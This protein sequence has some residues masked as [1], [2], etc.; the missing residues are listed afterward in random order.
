MVPEYEESIKRLNGLQS[1]AKV[2]QF[3]ARK[4][5]VELEKKLLETQWY[6]EKCNIQLE[7]IDQRNVIHVTGTKG[8]GST[9]AFTES[10]LRQLGFKTGFYRFI[11]PTYSSPHLIHHRERIRINGDPISESQFVFHFK[12]IYNCLEKAVMESKG[13]KSMP[14]FFQFL[15]ILAF[16]VFIE[17]KVD[18]AIIEVGIGGRYDCTNVIRNPVVSGVT[19][20][21][22]DHMS[23]LGNTLK[24]IA[25]Q[26]G[27]IFKSG[28]VAIVSKQSDDAMVIFRNLA[29]Y[30]N[31]VLRV[32][33]EFSAYGWPDNGVQCGI[34]GAHQQ[35]N[36]SLALQLAKISADFFKHHDDVAT[37]ES[38]ILPGFVVPQQFLDGIRLCNWPGRC[39]IVKRESITYYLD[40][41]HTPKS[42]QC[43]IDWFTEE[44]G[45]LSSSEQSYPYR[46]LLFNCSKGRSYRSFL[47]K[48]DNCGFNL[49]LFCP[50]LLH[51][52]NNQLSHGAEYK[53]PLHRVHA[54]YWRCFA[55]AAGE[56]YESVS[57]ALHRIEDLKDSVHKDIVVLV[58][59]SLHL[60]GCVLA[61]LKV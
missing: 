32:A 25:W 55:V 58:T 1:N 12:H 41:A 42:L 18:V 5:G 24:L 21:D 57:E 19:V 29:D 45:K 16:H 61:F 46:V 60:V 3:G 44:M 27:G 9:C 11:F 56:D 20:L 34:S 23:L 28:S 15:T 40:G 2:I 30:K 36:I 53:Y 35:I 6:L 4:K 22:Y 39:Q 51:S 26:K 13:D 43:C 49:A 54:S 10:I 52:M 7:E 31:C 17:E 33:P 37:S 14:G 38:E 8:K 59:G 47:C 48:L 50:N